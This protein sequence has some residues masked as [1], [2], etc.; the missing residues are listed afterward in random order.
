MG[1]GIMDMPGLESR[2][3]G[4][5][6]RYRKLFALLLLVLNTSGARVVSVTDVCQNS[7][8]YFSP[9][10]SLRAVVKLVTGQ[11]SRQ[12]TPRAFGAAK[13]RYSSLEIERFHRDERPAPVALLS[14][15][16]I[17]LQLESSRL[18]P[19]YS[20]RTPTGRSPVSPPLLV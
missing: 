17:T 14:P 3:V 10:R 18:R 8:V 16:S 11:K 12:R 2:L 6:R 19:V 4:S 5:M 15:V 13:N 20:W 1:R 7:R 9:A